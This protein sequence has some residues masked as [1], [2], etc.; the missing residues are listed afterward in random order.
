MEDV[1]AIRSENANLRRIQNKLVQW[2]SAEGALAPLT[3]YQTDVIQ[4]LAQ[5]LANSS[6]EVSVEIC[7]NWFPKLI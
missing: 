5:I 6:L 7:P 3:Q 4:T 2:D 1:A